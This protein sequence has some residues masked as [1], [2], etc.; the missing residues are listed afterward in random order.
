M[1]LV[2]REQVERLMV[3][4]GALRS[5][6]VDVLAAGPV[7]ATAAT[8][9]L[10]ANGR[11]VAV[12]LEA[13][14]SLGVAERDQPPPT[15]GAGSVADAREVAAPGPRYTLSA[16]G[17]QRLVDPGPELER[18]WLLH[19][20]NKVRSL[21]ELPFIITH[22]RQRAALRAKKDQKACALTMG[23]GPSGPRDAVVDRILGYMS[24]SRPRNLLDVGGAVGHMSARFMAR[25][26]RPTLLDMPE[27]IELAREKLGAVAAGMD[28]CACDFLRELPAG[29]YDLVFLGNI[30]HIYGPAR[31]R[32]LLVRAG[33]VLAP[34]GV[35][36]AVDFVWERSARAALFAVN[37]LQATLEGGVWRER[38]YRAWFA[39]AGLEDVDIQDL[40]HG[41]NQLLLARSPLG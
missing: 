17:R 27:V 22:G 33:R 5:G 36:A 25:G 1:T 3:L 34:G 15:S 11:A 13:L 32:D 30:F 4:A 8:V 31:N 16:L 12:M 35:V 39:E 14:V 37:M 41:S 24:P 18:N 10:Q 6:L 23:E 7:T 29:P 28:F 2:D 38:D 21:Y 20:S 26:I 40:A 19:Q 9:A